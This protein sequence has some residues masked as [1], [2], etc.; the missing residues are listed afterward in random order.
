MDA[1]ITT[2]TMPSQPNG[3]E[4]SSQPG[5]S[6]QET[7]TSEASSMSGQTTCEATLNATSSPALADGAMPCGLQ[8]GPT[9]DLFGQEVVPASLFRKRAGA[10]ANA[11]SATFGPN[12]G[13]S[14]STDA[15][16]TSLANRLRAAMD[17]NG[18]GM[19]ALTWKEWTTPLGPP[20]C[21]LRASVRRISGHACIG[22]P[23]V[24]ARE[25]KDWS[26][27]RILASL[28]RGDGVAKRICAI[29]QTFRASPEIV[30][31]NPCFARDMM[32]YPP[33]WQDCAPTVTPSSRKSQRNSSSRRKKQSEPTH[34]ES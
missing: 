19:F 6:R 22:L 26:Q 18:S 5:L 13:I 4:T 20:I 30:G 29:S 31:P 32:G 21:A 10:E 17:G 34:D 23:T 12:S 11:T 14:Y 24:S 28:D 1:P 2:R 3:S 8:D 15:L 9:T 25:G 33:A 27:A 16:Q 7:L